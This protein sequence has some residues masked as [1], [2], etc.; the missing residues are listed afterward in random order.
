MP[1]IPIPEDQLKL[2]GS[3]HAR[4]KESERLGAPP[5]PESPPAPPEWL[6]DAAAAHWIRLSVELHE[7]GILQNQDGST[8]ALFCER[9]AQY[10]ELR[11]QATTQLIITP[12]GERTHPLIKLR[13]E[14]HRD[15][16]SLAKELGLSASA[17]KGI[18]LSVPKPAK[19]GFIDDKNLFAKG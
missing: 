14:A 4:R 13:N 9:L 5:I 2:R 1:N 3:W 18:V 10:I 15:C 17:R 12:S 19:P 16:L 11:T 7:A 6:S 8:L